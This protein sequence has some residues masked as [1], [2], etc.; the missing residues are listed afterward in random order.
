MHTFIH[1]Y[2]HTYIHAYIHNTHTHTHTRYPS[3]YGGYPTPGQANP[4]TP[5]D[6]PT[7]HT[8][9]T[10]GGWGGA[11]TRRALC[12]GGGGHCCCVSF[13]CSAHVRVSLADPMHPRHDNNLLLLWIIF[14]YYHVIIF[15]KKIII[16]IIIITTILHDSI[17]GDEREHAVRPAVAATTGTHSQK[18]VPPSV[19]TI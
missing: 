16:I 5:G 18:S 2:I 8:P 1:T 19:F 17:R 12:V 4:Q 3:A 9:A 7:P 13:L 14:A 10:P 11:G 15:K 6:A